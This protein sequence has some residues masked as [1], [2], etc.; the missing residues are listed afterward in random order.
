MRCRSRLRIDD[1]ISRRRRVAL[2]QRTSISA[3]AGS[4]STD[5]VDITPEL[6]GSPT[7][8]GSSVTMMQSSDLRDFDD[9]ALH[10]HFDLSRSRRVPLQCLM[11]ARIVIIVEVIS[12]DSAQVI[13]TDDDQMI[14]TLS[15][16]R[17]DYAFGVW[18]LE[19]RSRRGDHLFNLH[20]LY[21]QSKF[22]PINLISI[23][24]PIARRRVFWEGFDELSGGP[25][26]RRMRCNI[27]VD[28]LTSV[29]QQDYE[30]V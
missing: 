30:T 24:E 1:S 7:L 15:A 13:F 22:F 26:S 23:P 29:M 28:D 5:L 10:R 4:P 25:F 20:P 9:L 16:N 3:C 2:Q 14:Q 8:C 19:G 17:A 18:I 11:R 21:S 6:T 27:E 12:Q